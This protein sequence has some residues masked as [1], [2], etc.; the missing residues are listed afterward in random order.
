MLVIALSRSRTFPQMEI[1]KKCFG[2]GAETSTRGGCASRSKAAATP[3]GVG[4]GTVRPSG[5]WSA[6]R[7]RAG[8]STIFG[9][10]DPP[11]AATCTR[12]TCHRSRRG[13]RVGRDEGRAIDLNRAP[14]VQVNRPYYFPPRAKRPPRAPNRAD[15]ILRLLQR[16]LRC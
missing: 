3:Q 8:S 12:R 2:E 10:A 11:L 9:E 13:S 4:N 15:A 7:G 16:A 1:R 5:R 14:A 6:A